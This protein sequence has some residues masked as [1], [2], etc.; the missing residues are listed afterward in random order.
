LREEKRAMLKGIALL[1]VFLVL[2]VVTF[3]LAFEVPPPQNIMEIP[4][5]DTLRKPMEKTLALFSLL[6]NPGYFAKV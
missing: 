3:A 6:I 2:D 5:G 4:N 1:A